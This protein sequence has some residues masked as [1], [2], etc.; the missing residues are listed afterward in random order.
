MANDQSWEYD[1]DQQYKI[2][3]HKLS[4]CGEYRIYEYKYL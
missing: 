1:D 3:Q 2:I 4:N